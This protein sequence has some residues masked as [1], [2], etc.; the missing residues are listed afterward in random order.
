[1]VKLSAGG[2]SRHRAFGQ[3]GAEGTRLAGEKLKRLVG[4]GP[5][6]SAVPLRF[7]SFRFVSFRFVGQAHLFAP[8]SQK[9]RK[10]MSWK[11]SWLGLLE[12]L[13]VT[14]PA[15]ARGVKRRRIGIRSREWPREEGRHRCPRA[16][17]HLLRKL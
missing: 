16:V 2:R 11:S 5:G 8:Q 13:K 3:T 9:Q 1:M 6:V 4:G 10:K 15:Y 17:V 12:R 7:V 14:C